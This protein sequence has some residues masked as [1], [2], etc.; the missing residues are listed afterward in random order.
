MIMYRGASSATRELVVADETAVTLISPYPPPNP[1]V[2]LCVSNKEGTQDVGFSRFTT[3]SALPGEYC[4]CYIPKPANRRQVVCFVAI[5]STLYSPTRCPCVTLGFN[6]FVC[7]GIIHKTGSQVKSPLRWFHTCRQ[8][9]K[10][11]V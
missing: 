9:Y 5:P 1:H 3:S 7:D 2:H 4:C 8:V 11:T 6:F 10:R